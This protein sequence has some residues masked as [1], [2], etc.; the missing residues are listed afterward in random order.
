MVSIFNG[1]SE[2]DA[3]VRNNLGYLICLKHSIRSREVTNR[4]FLQKDLFSFMRA[5]HV[6]SSRLNDISTK[7]ML[8]YSPNNIFITCHF[9]KLNPCKCD[10]VVVKALQVNI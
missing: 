5:Q 1:D 2:R 3:K 9:L 4:I 10:A 7:V 6:L 8:V